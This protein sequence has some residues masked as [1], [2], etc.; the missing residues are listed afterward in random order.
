L[1]AVLRWLRALLAITINTFREAI[2]NKVLGSLLFFAVLI[3]FTSLLLGQMSL[4]E[5]ERVTKDVTLFASTIFAA[6]ITI[7]SSVTLLHTEIERRTIYTILS[8]PIHRWQ[9]L[10]GKYLGVMLLM[11]VIVTALAGI[12]T[13]LLAVQ[14]FAPTTTLGWAFSTT[15][16]Q[17][18]IVGSMALFFASFS[19]PLLSGFIT[20]AIF[21]AGNLISQLEA[22][23]QLLEE[24]GIESMS[25]LLDVVAIVVP[26]LEKLN[27]SYEV[28]QGIAV[29]ATYLLP[30]TWYATSYS[31][32]VLAL[33][34]I[35]FARRDFI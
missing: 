17:M 31:A 27:L 4:H 26:S 9:F 1:E 6:I 10:L 3:I 12:S 28:T 24:R 22:M 18:M 19:S 30:A 33:A 5:E 16:L 20:A 8:K 34:M 21:V 11:A 29:E 14:G 15:Y 13:A 23:R 25:W 32:I 7:Y 2:R 35:I